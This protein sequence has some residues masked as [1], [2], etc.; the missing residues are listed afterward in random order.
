MATNYWIKLYHEILDDT[1]IGMLRVALKWRFVECLLAAGE[2]AKGGEL[3]ITAKLA[4]RL[5]CDPE[6]LESELSE[7]GDAGLLDLVDGIWHV[8]KFEKRQEPSGAAKRMREY[9]KRKK[10]EKDTD[11]DTYRARNALRNE[12][13]TKNEVLSLPFH[14]A[15]PPL[16]NAWGEYQQYNIDR[17][18][19]ITKSTALRL[20]KRFESMGEKKA[21]EAIEHSMDSN[22]TRLVEPTKKG[23]PSRDSSP[24]EAEIMAHIGTYGTRQD[25]SFNGD[26]DKVMRAA[27]GY[28]ALCK[29]SEWDAVKAI[30][31][32]QKAVKV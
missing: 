29:M 25:P 17:K 32:A 18:T 28:R 10:E 13:V 31:S 21:I 2:Y 26:T 30:R 1:K 16:L 8:T 4:W 7:L 11:T 12:T 9:R 5:R 27:G 23:G 6:Q 20:F 19:P 15:T 14:L 3:P 24:A 22:Y